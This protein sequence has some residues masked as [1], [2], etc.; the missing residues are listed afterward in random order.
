MT[1]T[2]LQQIKD[3]CQPL[4]AKTGRYHAW[5]HIELV[6]KWA[7]H[8]AGQYPE[9]NREVLE[10]ACYVHDIG[11]TKQD[12]GHPEI[13]AEMITPLLIKIN[14]DQAESQLL[15]EAVACHDKSKIRSATSI[16]AKLLF[17]ADK[18]QINSMYGF[19]RCAFWL[20]EERQMEMSQALHFL[21]T[22]VVDLN[23]NFM[24][25]PEGKKV[26]EAEFPLIKKMMAQFDDW[27]I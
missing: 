25:T 11:R 6:K 19:L 14:L 17:D 15:L 13:S 26:A 7:L 4:Y 5:D 22:Y 18:L 20:A 27:L 8:L 9:V 10:A 16:E 1:K 24:Q 21:Y 3:F 12:D 23:E 2:Q